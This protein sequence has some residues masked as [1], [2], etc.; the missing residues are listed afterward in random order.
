MAMNTGNGQTQAAIN[1]TPM[2]DVL[3]VLLIIFIAIAPAR[4]SGLDAAVPQPSP[5]GAPP[6][7]STPVVL[8]IAGDGSYRLN[9]EPVSHSAL[10]DRLMSVFSRR[11]GRVVFVKADDDLEFAVVAQAIDAAHEANIDKV[12]LMPRDSRR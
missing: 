4:S 3:L 11:V 10:R 5:A 7:E 1:V 9:S 8:Q 6:D 2:I 12:A